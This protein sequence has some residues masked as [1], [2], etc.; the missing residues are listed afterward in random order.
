MQLSKSTSALFVADI[1][2]SKAFYEQVLGM[3]VEFDFGGN[4]IYTSGFA[5][6]AIADDHV[7]RQQLGAEAIRCSVGNRFELYF[8][9]EDLQQVYDALKAHEVRFMHEPL[10]ES[11]GQQ[12]VR[13]FDPDGHLIEVGESMHRFVNRL[14]GEGLTIAQLVTLTHVPQAEVERLLGRVSG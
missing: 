10:T 8:E 12:T 2:V 3:E 1:D 11:W 7:I 13:F 9:T 4:V 5:I 14:H 6:W